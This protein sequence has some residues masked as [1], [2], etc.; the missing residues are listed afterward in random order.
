MSSLVFGGSAS[1]TSW[2]WGASPTGRSLGGILKCL[3]E[4][5]ECTDRRLLA[6]GLPKDDGHGQPKDGGHGSHSGQDDTV[7]TLPKHETQLDPWGASPRDTPIRRLGGLPN[8]QAPCPRCQV[9][10]QIFSKK[11][12]MLIRYDK[13]KKCMSKNPGTL[14]WLF[15]L[16]FQ[17]FSLDFKIF[18]N[19]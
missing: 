13:N 2:R 16:I 9:C 15:L 10:D 6:R 17:C 7:P 18:R 8:A 12:Q 5:C 4:R 3:M 14:N 1:S 19:F 11:K